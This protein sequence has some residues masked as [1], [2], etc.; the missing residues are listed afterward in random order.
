[1]AYILQ[2]ISPFMDR[3]WKAFATLVNQT[4]VYH[5]FCDNWPQ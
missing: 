4:I 1:M 2:I 5:V 3:Q